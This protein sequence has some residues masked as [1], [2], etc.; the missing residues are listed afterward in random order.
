MCSLT[1]PH[2]QGLSLLWTGRRE[3]LGTR[4]SLTLHI[5]NADSFIQQMNE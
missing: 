2:S 1:Q 4:L 3:I 5:F